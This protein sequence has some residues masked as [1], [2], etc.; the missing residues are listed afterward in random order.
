[1]ALF[2][3]NSQDCYKDCCKKPLT[4]NEVDLLDESFEVI[5]KLSDVEKS[6]LFYIAGYV[7]Q[8]HDLK[9]NEVVEEDISKS[10]FSEY[11]A[12]VSRGKLTFP[13]DE[14][15]DLTCVLYCYYKNVEKSCI[16]H[17]LLGFREIYE[18][19]CLNYDSGEKILRRLIN[20]FSKAFVLDS[21]D[22]SKNKKNQI[23]RRRLHGKAE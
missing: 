20:C 15:F 4:E 21:S 19:C 7:A 8:K 11:T 9:S 23:K 14:L 12:L 16:E 13:T 10:S 22:E 18:I 2:G 5:N 1:M 17:V 6:S 3:N